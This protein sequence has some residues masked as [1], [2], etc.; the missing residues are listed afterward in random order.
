MG[1]YDKTFTAMC[2]K[3]ISEEK[4]IN[5]RT[6]ENYDYDMFIEGK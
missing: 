1:K 3:I 4:I 5:E 6:I 2:E